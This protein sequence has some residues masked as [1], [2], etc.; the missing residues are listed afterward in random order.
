MK[1]KLIIL[2]IIVVLSTMFVAVYRL[3]FSKPSYLK[4][5]LPFKDNRDM[6][7]GIIQIGGSELDYDYSIVDKYFNF[8][9]FETIKFEGTEKYLIVPKDNPIEVYSLIMDEDGGMRE[10]YIKSMSEPFY[11]IC[12][13]SDIISNSLLRINVNGK[14]YS[15]SPYI[16]L[17]D[18]SL[19]VEDFVLHIKE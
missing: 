14:Q 13:I 4:I 15:Y 16:S 6:L 18:G 11:I 2:V 10:T 8:R 5:E 3:I 1:K 7:L 9:D 19:I 17:K 12:N